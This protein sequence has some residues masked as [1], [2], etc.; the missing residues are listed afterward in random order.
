MQKL[1]QKSLCGNNYTIKCTAVSN[2]GLLF[3]ESGAS[4]LVGIWSTSS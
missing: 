4:G 2:D 3:V 1:C